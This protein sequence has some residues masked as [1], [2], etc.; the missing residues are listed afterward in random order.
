MKNDQNELYME[1][2]DC[3]KYR[4]VPNPPPGSIGG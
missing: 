2:R 4:D 1:C 3:G